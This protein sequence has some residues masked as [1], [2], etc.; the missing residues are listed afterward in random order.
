M[1]K[2]L[3][4]IFSILVALVITL[5]VALP[6]IV[7]NRIT[8][9]DPFTFEMVLSDP[10]MRNHFGIQNNTNP[11]DYGFASEEI[12][13]HSLDGTRL[14]GW[15]I[16][17]KK[18]S[19]HCILFIHGR[20]SNRLKTMKYLALIDSLDLDTLYNIFI[21]DLR[22]SGKSHPGK[23]YMG[24]KFGE[25]VTAS[26]LVMDSLYQQN[27][28]FLYGFSMG[29]MAILNA[30]GRNDLKKKYTN[31]SIAIE[32][33]ILDS[34]LVNVKETLKGETKQSHVPGFIFNNMF[35]LYSKEINYFGENM[36]ISSLLDPGIPTL[37]MQSKDDE[38][39]VVNILQM[40]LSAMNNFDKLETVYFE[41][42]GHVR[43]Y[44]DENTNSKY[45]NSVRNFI[46]KSQS[47]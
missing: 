31:K 18:K 41:G 17:A 7:L 10:E 23:T 28:F 15:Y 16:P 22:N 20:T 21:P 1:K 29:A 40:E 6:H 12:N 44:Q 3:T 30:A 34:P 11:S 42:P 14:N 43:M 8:D 47:N 39:T 19:D 5:Y 33:I 45:I 13:F 36:N 32:K 38:T 25:D 37:I 26:I 24:Y 35:E 9:Y 2:K 4:I 46:L 27:T